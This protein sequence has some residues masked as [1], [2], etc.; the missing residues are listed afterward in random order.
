MVTFMGKGENKLS[1]KFES[2]QYYTERDFTKAFDDVENLD[3]V[4]KKIKQM[5]KMR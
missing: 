5:K 3:L 1:Y 4:S 2:I